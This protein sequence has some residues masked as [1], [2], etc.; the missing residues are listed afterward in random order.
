MT[1]EKRN[2]EKTVVM[3]GMQQRDVP[4][5]EEMLHNSCEHS[6][7]GKVTVGLLTLYGEDINQKI[8]QQFPPIS[9]ENLKEALI[10]NTYHS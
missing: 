10:T 9:R 2:L 6:Y 5:C 8:V 7:Q 3:I 4:S 1:S